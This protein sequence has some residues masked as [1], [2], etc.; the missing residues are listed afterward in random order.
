MTG[1]VMFLGT[2]VVVVGLVV[3]IVTRTWDD[4][5]GRLPLLFFLQAGLRGIV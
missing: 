2:V 5:L 3:D 1:K 4:V